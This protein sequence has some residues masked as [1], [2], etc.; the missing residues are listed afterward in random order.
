MAVTSKVAQNRE[1]RKAEI[2]ARA[3]TYFA[4]VG[5][6]GTTRGLAKELGCSQ[7]MFYRYFPN[8]EDLISNVFS[9][10][11]DESRYRLLPE[12]DA[13]SGVPL[14]KQLSNLL[15]V[16]CTEVMNEEWIRLFFFA[17]LSGYTEPYAA[18][19]QAITDA[20]LLPIC[21]IVR[22]EIGYDG[23]EM[24]EIPV[25]DVEYELAWRPFGGIIYNMIRIH[26]FK[27][28]LKVPLED[29][30]AEVVD[31]HMGGWYANWPR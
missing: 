21:R 2:V 11:F 1:R 19:K 5:L 14:R 20:V 8:S 4:R 22:A 29:I 7:A 16:Y 31:Q 6:E 9:S 25:S 13:E 3:T 30:I 24:D 27:I 18:N 28:Q 12:L 23:A 15:Y 17:S 26:I 10:T